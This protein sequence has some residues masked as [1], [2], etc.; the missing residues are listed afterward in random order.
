MLT[1]AHILDLDT[2]FR[3][4]LSS[5]PI[6]LRPDPT[7]EQ[8]PEVRQE[9]AQRPYLAMHRLI[10][11]EAVNQRLLVLHRD[12]MCRGHHDEKFAYSTRVAV[13][14]ARTILS[15]RQQIDNVH[16]AVQKHAAFRHHLFQA[17][18]VL[19]IHLLE[20]SHKAQ[21]E[22]QVAHQLRDDIA[23]IMN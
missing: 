16:P 8:L 20:L 2:K 4:L 5:L 23:L 7:L 22:S 12:D 14:A 21:G 18:I 3:A 10:V 19:S 11:F 6:F 9:Q 1:Y 13:D 15:C 17:A